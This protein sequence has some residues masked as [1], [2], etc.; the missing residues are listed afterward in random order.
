[1]TSGTNYRWVTALAAALLAGLLAAVV[2]PR[3]AEDESVTWLVALGVALVAG[4]AVVL[5]TR[6][7]IDDGA[8]VRDDAL[9]KP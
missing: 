1:M 3:V 2:T 9:P 6:E 5:A 7:K 4:L 8:H